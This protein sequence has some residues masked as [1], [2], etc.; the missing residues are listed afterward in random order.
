M[1]TAPTALIRLP[2]RTRMLVVD[3]LV[4]LPL[5]SLR[6]E[7]TEGV[8]SVRRR[9][10]PRPVIMIIGS[11][12]GIRALDREVPRMAALTRR[13]TETIHTRMPS[14]MTFHAR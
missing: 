7:T 1:T 14:L 11:G 9:S 5:V 3:R 13:C 10:A 8:T 6:H 4:V 12:P 2:A